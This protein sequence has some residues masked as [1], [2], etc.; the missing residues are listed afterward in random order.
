MAVTDGLLPILASSLITEEAIMKKILIASE[1]GYEEQSWIEFL[2][3]GVIGWIWIAA[4]LA[5][6]Y[7]LVRAVFFG[8]GWWQA[9]ASVAAAWFLYKY[10]FPSSLPTTLSL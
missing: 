3:V 5:A 6:V 8:D 10:A 4:S 1:D 2:Y 9:V 7:F